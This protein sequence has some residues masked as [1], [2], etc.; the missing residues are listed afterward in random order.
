VT[1]AGYVDAAIRM[2]EQG[3]IIVTFGDMVRVPGSHQSL[4]DVRAQGGDVRI[5]Y[6]PAD[7]LRVAAENPGRE[8]VFLAI[9]FETTAAPVTTLIP[10]ARQADIRNLSLLTA[11]KRVP[12]ALEALVADEEV[13]VDGFICP[14][15]VSAI[16]GAEAY[17]PCVE[18][19]HLP[20]TICG[21][22]PLDILYGIVDLAEQLVSGRAE[23]VNQYSRVVRPGG[24]PAALQLFEKYLT[25]CDASWRGIGTIPDSGMAIRGEFVDM[26]AARRFGVSTEGGRPDPGC[27][28]GDVLKGKIIP[29]DCPHFGHACTPPHPVGPCMVSSE[30]SCAAFY[31]YGGGR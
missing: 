17:R 7:A 3:A 1:D 4:A 15:H 2:A 28:C 14:A 26:D 21:F 20:C 5:C 25:V 31:R 23:L 13:Q 18:G 24:N 30:G 12:P 6:S 16:I 8:V 27:R 10:S 9:G 29:P 11:F 19:H 22:E